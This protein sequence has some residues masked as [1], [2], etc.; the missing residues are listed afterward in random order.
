VAYVRDCAL[1]L[2]LVCVAF[3]SLISVLLGD[4]KL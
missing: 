2:S 1:V 3:P 4:H